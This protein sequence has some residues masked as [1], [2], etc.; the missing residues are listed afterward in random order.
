VSRSRAVEAE[1]A[2]VV[3][4]ADAEAAVD[5]AVQVSLAEAFHVGAFHE[6]D[7]LAVALRFAAVGPSR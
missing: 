2:V 3:V 7:S 1:A 4:V 5:S 6:A